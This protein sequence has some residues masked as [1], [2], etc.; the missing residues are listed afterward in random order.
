M[1]FNQDKSYTYHKKILY[2]SKQNKSKVINQINFICKVKVVEL[3]EHFFKSVVR[4]IC[5]KTYTI[6]VYFVNFVYLCR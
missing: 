1:V 6:L 3:N 2:K 5:Y 4:F